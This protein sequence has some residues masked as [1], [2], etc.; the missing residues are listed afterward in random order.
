MAK[1]F[2]PKRKAGKVVEEVK[3]EEF[4]AIRFDDVLYFGEYY[5]VKPT[6]SIAMTG[7][8][9]P[10]YGIF[11]S[12]TGIMEADTRQYPAALQWANALDRLAK[13]GMPDLPDEEM[14][15]DMKIGT[16]Q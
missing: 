8:P 16:L 5:Y 6:M 1:L 4:D 15:M 14:L 11:N 9:Y 13:E 7:E 10:A 2:S 3:S 12:E